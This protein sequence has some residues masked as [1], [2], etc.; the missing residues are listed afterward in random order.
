[1]ENLEIEVVSYK[2]YRRRAKL[3]AR[4]KSRQ[5]EYPYDPWSRSRKAL[6]GRLKRNW[7]FDPLG[8][9][10]G[11]FTVGEDWN[12]EGAIHVVCLSP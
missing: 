6:I 3:E 10:N 4:W 11:D 7:S 1:M 5:G 2:E 12:D 8:Y 9:G